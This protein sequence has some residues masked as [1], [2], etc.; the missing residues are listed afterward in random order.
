[1]NE[2]NHHAKPYDQT[3][4]SGEW[5]VVNDFEVIQHNLGPLATRRALNNLLNAS[6]RY[7]Q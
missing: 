3:T 7:G 1:M 6:A 2:T 4:P 5:N